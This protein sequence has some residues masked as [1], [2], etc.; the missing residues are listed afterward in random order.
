MIGVLCGPGWAVDQVTAPGVDL[1]QVVHTQK[2][3]TRVHLGLHWW[4]RACNNDRATFILYAPDLAKK[5]RRQLYAY[6][7]G[8]SLTVANCDVVQP[9]VRRAKNNTIAATVLV[10]A[11][12]LAQTSPDGYHVNFNPYLFLVAT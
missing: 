6:P 2:A 9:I 12:L 11:P 8:G 1:R 4:S 7:G 3:E 5:T 10:A